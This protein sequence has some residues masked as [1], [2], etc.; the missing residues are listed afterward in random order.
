MWDGSHTFEL[1]KPGSELIESL[2]DI[3]VREVEDLGGGFVNITFHQQHT[4]NVE[5]ILEASG[6]DYRLV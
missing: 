4:E 6:I 3:G 1:M 2:K 5:Q